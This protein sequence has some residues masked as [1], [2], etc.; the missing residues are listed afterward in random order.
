MMVPGRR[1]TELKMG[2]NV[3]QLKKDRMDEITQH[4]FEFPGLP[5]MEIGQ[6]VKIN[7]IATEDG[8]EGPHDIMELGVSIMK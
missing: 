4:T 6:R 5:D 7:P 2:G 1:I 3:L 8:R